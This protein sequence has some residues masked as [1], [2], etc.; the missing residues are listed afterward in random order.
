[1]FGIFR[2]ILAT[3]VVVAH[4]WTPPNGISII[5]GYAVYGFFILSGYLMTLVTNTKYGFTPSGIKTFLINRGLRIYP[6]Y[7]LSITLTLLLMP[8]FGQ[9]A[10]SDFHPKFLLPTT[11]YDW[12]SNLFIFGLAKTG[13]LSL[14]SVILS[15]PA[16]ALEI[17]L[18]FYILIGLFLGKKKYFKPWLIGTFAT[19]I[20][21]KLIFKVISSFTGQAYGFSYGSLLYASLAFCLGAFIFH[22]QEQI[23]QLKQKV[24][25]SDFFLILGLTVAW[26]VSLLWITPISSTLGFL[27]NTVIM[28]LLIICLMNSKSRQ[29]KNIDK[30]LGDLSYPMYLFH[31]QIAFITFRLFAFSQNKSAELFAI[32]F[33]AILVVSWL[34]VVGFESP[35]AAL[36][37]RVRETRQI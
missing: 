27:V 18:T 26:V 7:W 12:F 35:I 37:H 33:P 3:F 2:F 9:I 4:I 8:I 17:E 6:T 29:L 25:F 5:G 11:L 10:L 13:F 21:L 31:Y 14:H 22:Y 16:W 24:P 1:M 28:F 32:S 36:R 23:Y 34:I 20:G 15:P 19:I 30:I